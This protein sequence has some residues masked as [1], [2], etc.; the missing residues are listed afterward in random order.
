MKKLYH[1]L[2]IVM[3]FIAVNGCSNRD[4]NPLSV[5]ENDIGTLTKSTEEQEVYL[6]KLAQQLAVSLNDQAIVDLLKYEF[7]TT[8]TCEGILNF[9]DLLSK[10]VNG[11]TFSKKITSDSLKSKYNLGKILTKE[12]IHKLLNS[13]DFGLDLYFPYVEH[14]QKWQSIINQILIAYPPL[15]VDDNK[16]K[17][18]T[19]FTLNGNEQL[20]SAKIPPAEPVLIISPCEHHGDHSI[21]NNTLLKKTHSTS[22]GEWRLTIYHFKLMDDH[23][24]WYK[25]NAEIYVKLL[26]G[27]WYRTDCYSIDKEKLIGIIINL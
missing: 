11:V 14:R 3:F 19:A 18:I 8:N 26:E 4:N 9:S 15:S 23:E 20:L 13:F 6:S 10:K 5:Q 17:K 25:G 27:S 21:E 12:E 16:C 22:S 2:A 1:I 24:P 7:E